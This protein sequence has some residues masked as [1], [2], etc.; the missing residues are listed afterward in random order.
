MLQED[1][2]SGRFARE[3]SAEQAEGQDRLER[4]RAQAEAS[5]LA[6]AEAAVRQA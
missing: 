3:W 5:P 2:L 6:R 4:L 1:I